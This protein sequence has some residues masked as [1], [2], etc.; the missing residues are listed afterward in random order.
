MAQL[1]AANYLSNSARTEAEM[2]TALE[3]LRDVIAEMGSTNPSTLQITSG[4]LE[5]P[6]SHFAFARSEGHSTGA[7]DVMNTID[8]AG[9]DQGRM[10]ILRNF[11][12][13]SSETANTERITINHGGGAKEMELSDSTSFILCG[14][15]M[16]AFVYNGTRWIELWRSYHRRNA[17][18]IIAERSYLGLGDASTETIATSDGSSAN[19]KVLKVGSSANLTANDLLS[20]DGSG[21]IVTGSVTGGN[22]DTLDSYDST[23]FLRKADTSTH[24]IAANLNIS[25]NGSSRFIANTNGTSQNP[26]LQMEDNGTTRALVFYDQADGSLDIRTQDTGGSMTPSIRLNPTNDR[27]EFVTGTGASWQSLRPGP[28]NGLDADTVDGNHASALINVLSILDSGGGSYTTGEAGS[29][30]LSDGTTT[31]LVQW[32]VSSDWTNQ[33]TSRFNAYSERWTFPTA[34]ADVPIILGGGLI[35]Y[36][37][38]SVVT[39]DESVASPW[40]TYSSDTTMWRDVTSTYIEYLEDHSNRRVSLT[41]TPIAIGIAAS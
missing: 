20:I 11:D 16:I 2:Q 38:S 17:E 3:S 32:P 26:G 1:P 12:S 27:L 29:F 10:V 19:S 7:D 21:N 39:F 8:T 37:R 30:R 28:G 33:Y 22:A 14:E 6:T 34:Y 35:R 4:E 5:T 15:R 24:T 25:T 40:L 9:I 31:L 18:D 23:A 13:T 36:E 41:G